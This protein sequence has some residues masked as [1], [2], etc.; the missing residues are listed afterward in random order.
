MK[1]TIHVTYYALLRQERGLPEETIESEAKTARELFNELKVRYS[2]KL[3]EH[4]V[5]A[6]I[7]SK[8]ASWDSPLNSGDRI[9]LIPPVAGG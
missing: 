5:K 1:K 9:L 3:S 6:A 8:V 7:N 4:Q 2:F